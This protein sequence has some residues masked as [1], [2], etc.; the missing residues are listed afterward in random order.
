MRE[1][2]CEK[3]DLV[4]AWYSKEEMY[5]FSFITTQVCGNCGLKRQKHSETKEWWSYS[6]ERENEPIINIRPL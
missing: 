3:E 1:N 4:H 6:D 5:G 2:K